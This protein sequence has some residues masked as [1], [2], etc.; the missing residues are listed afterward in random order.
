M[1]EIK[2]LAGDKEW[3]NIVCVRIIEFLNLFKTN[4]SNYM[5]F[6]F[7]EVFVEQMNPDNMTQFEHLDTKTTDKHSNE[8]IRKGKLVDIKTHM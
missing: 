7:A 5:V 1:E 6:V 3:I 2:R 8:F 4:T